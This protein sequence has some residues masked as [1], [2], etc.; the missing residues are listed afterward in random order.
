MALPP[1]ALSKV[2][3][4]YTLAQSETV[5]ESIPYCSRLFIASGEGTDLANTKAMQGRAKCKTITQSLVF[6]LMKVAEKA[7]DTESIKSYWN[8]FYCQ[9][10]VISA[11]G[12]LYGKYC[13][14]RFCT[15][16]N[17]IR[18]AQL[19]N[20][21]KPHI[22]LWPDPHL[23]TL[24]VKSVSKTKLKQ[25]IDSM[26]KVWCVI[27]RKHKKRYQRA[28][29]IKLVGIRALECNFNSVKRTYNPH[30]HVLV[31]DRETADIIRAEWIARAKP[32]WVSSKAQ[33]VRQVVNTE[34]DL[35]E[36]IKY[37]IKV[38]M[39]PDPNR[40][41]K[42]SD[43]KVFPAAYS[44]ILN[45]MRGHRLFERF[46]FNVAARRGVDTG[47]YTVL[48]DYR[49]WKFDPLRGDWFDMNTNEPLTKYEL[50]FETRTMLADNFEFD[51]D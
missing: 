13:K 1:K 21:Y 49:K 20:C 46:G 15:V 3:C 12:R 23:V 24:T 47:K 36:V 11:N 33:D 6:G 34:S 28:K 4:I 51:L 9:H 19:I 35:V 38:F 7:G 2:G 45:A 39:E 44:T 25:V 30:F 40:K 50:P 29:G 43:M 18:K 5:G 32:G 31:P 41:G 8:T 37:G 48:A 17:R 22:E 14:N 10:E 27:L 42:K 16:C 26:L